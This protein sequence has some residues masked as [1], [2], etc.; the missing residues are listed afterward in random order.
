MGKRE[1]IPAVII[2]GYRYRAADER[3]TSVIRPAAEDL[4]R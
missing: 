1:G 4:F 3:A 2:S